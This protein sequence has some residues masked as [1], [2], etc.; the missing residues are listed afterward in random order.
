MALRLTD[1][2]KQSQKN[3]IFFILIY[4]PRP[5]PMDLYPGASIAQIRDAFSRDSGA[6]DT[7]STHP[8]T[9]MRNILLNYVAPSTDPESFA[10]FLGR[11]CYSTIEYGILVPRADFQSVRANRIDIENRVNGLWSGY[12]D[13]WIADLHRPGCAIMRP[14]YNISMSLDARV[15]EAAKGL[16]IIF[17]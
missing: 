1:R 6:I 2:A 13:I 17:S 9:Q 12:R 5:P 15:K 4:F 7:N 11:M 3:L 14:G 10:R 8:V 16:N